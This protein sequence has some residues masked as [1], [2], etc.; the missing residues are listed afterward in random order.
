MK[1]RTL[2]ADISRADVGQYSQCR[3]A[4]LTRKRLVDYSME[5]FIVKCRNR[6][7]VAG[8]VYGRVAGDRVF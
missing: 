8:F 2:Q 7:W 5:E 3:G 6:L 1:C 4:A